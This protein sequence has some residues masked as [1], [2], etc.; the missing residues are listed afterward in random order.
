MYSKEIIIPEGVT[1][2]IEKNKVKISGSKGEIKREFKLA[3]DIKLQKQDSKI[4]VL[5]ES[6]DRKAK[7][8]TGT[9]IAHI[10]NMI[11]GVIEGYTY[12]MKIIYSHFPMTVKVDSGK[13]VTQNFLGERTQRTA[14]IIGDTQVKIEG[15]DMT[16]TGID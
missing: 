9:I 15:Q 3:H 5:S 6:S 10:R 7:A 13:V 4:T 16:I 11:K 14:K 1:A 2:E 12:K 8:L